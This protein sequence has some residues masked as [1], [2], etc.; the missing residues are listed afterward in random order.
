VKKNCILILDYKGNINVQNTDSRA[1]HKHY[2]EILSALSTENELNLVVISSGD[3]EEFDSSGNAEFYQIR[4]GKFNPIK[5]IFTSRKTIKNNGLNAKVLVC[6]DPWESF[7]IAKAVQFLL[8]NKPKLQV[9][10]HADIS[11]SNWHEQSLKRKIRSKFQLLAIKSSD[12]VR[13]VSEK[14]KDYVQSIDESKEVIIA[15]IPIRLKRKRE[16][17]E[18]RKRNSLVQIGFFGRLHPDRGTKELVKIVEKLNGQRDDFRIVIAGEGPDKDF[19]IKSLSEI[20]SE[21]RFIYLGY[22]DHDTLG[23]QLEYLDVYLSLAPAE[24]YGLGIREAILFGVPVVAIESNGSIHA[25]RE[26]G[27]QSISIIR[28]DIAPSELSLIVDQALLSVNR[29]DVENII[30]KENEINVEKLIKS[31]LVLSSFPLN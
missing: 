17:Q 18:L 6:G 14:L 9:Q 25:Q 29:G 8:R 13:V 24:S 26:F 27:N 21:D 15:P 28:A 7:L 5:F 3:V 11:D 16:F 1:R 31:W 30:E 12:Q 22:L 19:L 20:L 4:C 10:I 23:N 2:S